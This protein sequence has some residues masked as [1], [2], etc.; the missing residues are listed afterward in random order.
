MSP[1]VAVTLYA[2][3]ALAAIAW[4]AWMQWGRERYPNPIRSTFGTHAGEE[5]GVQMAV[6]T[7][8]S[9]RTGEVGRIDVYLQNT[10]DSPRTAV[11]SVDVLGY[12]RS[13]VPPALDVELGPLEAAVLSVPFVVEESERPTVEVW[14]AIAVTGAG[15][16]RRRLWRAPWRAG[17]S[18]RALMGAQAA[19]LARGVAGG[20][21]AR[22]TVTGARAPVPA[23]PASSLCVIWPTAGTIASMARE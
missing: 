13:T 12:A 14:T 15:G 21:P 20:I 17:Q 4:I 2:L 6:A 9:I 18:R 3:P 7:P 23:L 19:A 10:W 16:R 22:L 5:R 8:E 11:V 1:V